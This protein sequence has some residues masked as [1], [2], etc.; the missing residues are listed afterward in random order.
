LKL[1]Q[2]DEARDSIASSLQTALQMKSFTILISVLPLA[3]CVL[4]S[5]GRIS[6]AVELYALASRYSY[7]SNSR[8]FADVV[9]QPVETA[10]VTLSP[11]AVVAAQKRG[12][13]R[14]LWKTA[15]E[16]LVE[17]QEGDGS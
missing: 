1:G 14:D 17:L 4:V 2:I 9:G 15:A 12:R 7:V 10:A 16:L 8:W 6:Q 5:D 13:E 11:E 3:A